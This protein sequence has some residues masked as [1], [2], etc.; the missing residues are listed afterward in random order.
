M[1]EGTLALGCFDNG[2]KWLELA[3][4][5]RFLSPFFCPLWPIP[6]IF[7]HY[8]NSPRQVSLLTFTNNKTAQADVFSGVP[9]TVVY[10]T[11]RTGRQYPSSQCL[12]YFSECGQLWH[13]PL[14]VK[15][16]RID[17]FAFMLQPL[18]TREKCKHTKRKLIFKK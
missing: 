1:S 8:Q 4:V 6:A 7:C 18:P 13:C 11:E 16:G 17:E 9:A 10:I 12:V 15:L 3:N 2:R 14:K 5:G